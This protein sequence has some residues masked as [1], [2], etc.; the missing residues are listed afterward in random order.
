[1][2][3]DLFEVWL[4]DRG[5]LPLTIKSYLTYYKIFGGHGNMNQEYSNKFIRDHS[6]S[7]A[8]R[9]F[10]KNYRMFLITIYANDPQVN[11]Q[12][13]REVEL[14]EKVGSKGFKIPKFLEPSDIQRIYE[15]FQTDRDKLMFQFQYR[16]GLRVSELISIMP[17][18]FN[19]S[20]WKE[21]QKT[22]AQ[23]KL[24]GYLT[25]KKA[26]GN[27]QRIV[28][29]PGNV[30]F[31]LT[32]YLFNDKGTSNFHAYKP[33]FSIQRRRWQ[34]LLENASVRAGV[35]PKRKHGEI[36]PDG[37]NINTHCLRHTFAM[38]M[39]R[40][41]FTIEEIKVMLGHESISTTM[42]YAR[43]NID[44]IRKKKESFISKEK[45]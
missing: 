15:S 45:S 21:E 41:G 9:A 30:M 3:I 38:E 35:I 29:V 1:M 7:S 25:V 4:T 12:K 36:R 5:L 22:T 43:S 20:K 8:A 31:Q 14:P 11:L 40:E 26:K 6:G 37:E 19:W 34:Q 17:S 27:K 23:E 28:L 39:L 33:I 18:D 10:V 44:D 24:F 42:I 16:C 32:K 13:I 2:E